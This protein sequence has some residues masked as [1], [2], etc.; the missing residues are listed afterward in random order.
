M[1][2]VIEYT[3]LQNFIIDFLIFKTTSLVL[4]AKCRFVF[5]AS[6]LG[7]VVALIIPI[8]NLSGVAEFFL[9][10]FLAVILVSLTFPYSKFSS[11]IKIYLCFFFCTFLYGGICAFF[12]QSFGQLHALLFLVIV[13]VTYLIF[14]YLFRFI[15]KRKEI[16]NFCFEVKLENEG[17]KCACKGFLDTGNLLS[18][19]L[20][21][22]PVSL[23]SYKLFNKLFNVELSD[24]LTNNLDTKNLKF[25]HY[26]N[27]GTVSSSGKVLAFEIDKIVI[28]DKALEKPILA[29]CLKNFKS[30]EMILNS[31]FA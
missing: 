31:S 15:N 7:A 9:K 6:I 19:P 28:G 12:V 16:E 27:L 26:I 3:L 2:I 18:D 8:F 17:K 13:I 29:L 14:K 24:I 5:L 1:E 4:R 21:N 11:F 23:I 25:A 30:Y 20:T 10:L 22:R